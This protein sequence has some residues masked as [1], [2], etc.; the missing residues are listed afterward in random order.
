MSVLWGHLESIVVLPVV[1]PSLVVAMRDP[2]GTLR[3]E[4]VA[5]GNTRIA[6]G[7]NQVSLEELRPDEFAVVT[8]KEHSG[9]LEAERTDI[10]KFAIDSAIGVRLSIG[11]TG[12]G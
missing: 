7:L 3:V 1:S 2:P 8:A 4:Y 9:W 11:T 6:R 10:I 12:R 5:G